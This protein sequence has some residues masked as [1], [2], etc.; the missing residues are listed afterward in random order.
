M[1]FKR[2][3]SEIN[4]GII[5]PL[6]L[7]IVKDE[8]IAKS[9]ASLIKSKAVTG[10]FYD[11]NVSVF[12]DKEC[13]PAQIMNALMTMPV[14]SERRCVEID[15]D[16][17]GK[18]SSVIKLLCD[19]AESPCE[20]TVLIVLSSQINNKS[21][22][23]NVFSSNGKIVEFDKLNTYQLKDWIKA[24]FEKRGLSIETD[25]LEFMVAVAEYNTNESEVDVG[26]FAN[27]IE[28]ISLYDTLIKKITVDILKKLQSKNINDDIFK[29]TDLI[30][31][32]NTEK[33]LAQLDK[34]LANN[35]LPQQ[36]I[37]SIA[38]LMKRIAICLYLT[39]NGYSQSAI[40][41]NYRMHPYAVKKACEAKNNFSVKD[42]LCAI[43]VLDA[44]DVM[45]KSGEMDAGSAL[46]IAVA[47][48]ASKTFSLSGV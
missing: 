5:G 28:K 32:A 20:E 9:Y 44:A 25:A 23:Y 47:D 31:N 8:Y 21:L 39:E 2:L 26:Y 19:Y 18:D 36:I 3:Q 34:L 16:V 41:K 24:A 33:S 15:L 14:M 40:S 46:F 29:L 4:K 17:F 11:M 38:S 27:E 10:D 48:I 13:D 12:D 42:A 22:I 43:L 35:A 37:S 30:A 45:I 7:F 1:N 6:Y